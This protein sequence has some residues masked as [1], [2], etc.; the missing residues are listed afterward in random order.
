M[1]YHPRNYQPL[2]W[3]IRDTVEAAEREPK[4]RE[5][6]AYLTVDGPE[7]A[8]FSSHGSTSADCA[9][10]AWRLAYILA[11]DSGEPLTFDD[12]DYCMGL[13]VNDRDDVRYIIGR[14]GNGDY[15]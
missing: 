9:P 12:L 10:V 3:E 11:R 14:Y 8:C 5:G 6:I 13:V 2:G 1:N 4:R 15:R 7:L